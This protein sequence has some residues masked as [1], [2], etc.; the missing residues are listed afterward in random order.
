MATNSAAAILVKGRIL[1]DEGLPLPGVSVKAK[2]EKAATVTDVNGNYSISV[3]KK[4]SVIQFSFLGF[5]S[6]ETTVGD[7]TTINISLKVIASRLNEVVVVGYGTVQKRDLTGAVG[8]VSMKDLQKAP[9]KSFDEA[10]AGRV[11][12]VQVNSDDGQPGS[13]FNIVIRGQNSITQDNSPLYVIDG[14]PIEAANNNALNTSDIESIE[15]LKDASATAIYG[16][17]GANGVILITTKSGKKGAPV[18]EYSGNFGTQE[19]VKTMDLLSPYEFVKLQ[20]ELNQPAASAL[21]L[22]NGN[23]LDTYKS[24]K[25]IDW[26]NE[27]FRSSFTQQH[28]IS[29]SGGTDNTQYVI[30][31]SINNQDGVIINSGFK[32]NQGKISLTQKVNDKLKIYTNLNYANIISDGVVPTSGSN[33]ATNNLLYSTWGYRPISSSLVDLT[34]VLFDPD[35]DG[36]NDY[37]INPIISSNNELRKATN[38]NLIVNTYA[39]YAFSKKL[40]LKVSG[41]VTNNLRRNDLF[42]NSL[43]YYGNPNTAGG[44]NGVNGSVIFTQN[45][46]WANE[47]ILTYKEKFNKNHELTVLG[48]VSFQEDKYSRYGSKAIQVP[49]ESLGLDGLDEGVP[50]TINAESSNAT[51]ESFL[52]RVMYNYKSKY[53]ATASFRADGSS[54]FAP[55]KRWSYFPSV[56]V[57]WRMSSESFMKNLDFIYDAKLRVGYGVTGNNRVGDFSYLSVLGQPTGSPYAFNNS[58]NLGAIPVALGNKDLKWESTAQANIGYDLSLF[59]DK[60]SLTA[61]VYRKTTYDLLLDAD[62]PYSTG[63]TTAFMNIGKVRN[64]GLELSLNTTN[65]S[66]RDFKWS[67]SINISFNKSKVLGLSEGQQF[68]TTP[69]S[70]ENSYNSTPLYIAKVN[71]PI[72]SFYGY[73]WDGVYQVSD[74]DL[75]GGAY[76]LKADVP[77]NGN[78]RNVIQPGDIKYK[79]IAGNDNI[80]NSDDRTVIGRGQPIHTGGFN[81]NFSYKNFD[82]NVFFQWSYGNDIYNANRMIF[83]GNMLA[84]QNLNQFASY[85]D[86]WTPENP[87]NT[88]YRVNGQG[89]RVYSSRL[90]EDGSFLRLKTVSLGYAFKPQLIKPIGLKTLRL[91]VSGQ[92]LLTWTNYSGMDPEVSIRNSAL[93]PGFDYSA[94]PRARTIVFGLSTSL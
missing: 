8:Q 12:G 27:L 29:L 51:L 55:G 92:N 1:D 84:K 11:A 2:N 25:G 57:A 18:I 64:E 59:K 49:N 93:T 3:E 61:D 54:K 6:Q 67:S 24:V 43:T 74:F 80:V 78:A 15:V 47:N 13:N 50:Q 70:W 10:L 53:L 38:N 91:S 4:T 21:Y 71:E 77:N 22:S 56:S 83:D 63:Y 87:S 23:T 73:V 79:D 65:I 75:I 88:L 90:I 48:G 33:S 81:N 39:Q 31:G 82:L 46:S 32:R 86:R 28:N 89:P 30:S 9:V 7:R 45:S 68:R 26:Q 40:T 72:A 76:V 35:I 20:L 69:V 60:L 19:N 44:V 17:R 41:A 36:S 37:R 5:E 62:L 58:I 34:N 16:S 14:F 52:S 66:K 94:Y 42:Y 85:A